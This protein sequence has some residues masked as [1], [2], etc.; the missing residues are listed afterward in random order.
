MSIRGGVFMTKRHN[1][2]R[3][4]LF[5]TVA[6]AILIAGVS[7]AFAAEDADEADDQDRVV[8][9]GHGQRRRTRTGV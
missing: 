3:S 6:A 1:F 7:P 9:V 4:K 5:S 8:N 2:Y